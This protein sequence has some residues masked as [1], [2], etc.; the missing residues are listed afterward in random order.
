MSKK[1]P[2]L[3]HIIEIREMLARW[4]HIPAQT[5]ANTDKID[6]VDKKIEKISTTLNTLWSVILAIPLIGAIISGIGYAIKVTNSV[7]M[8]Q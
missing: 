4:E 6:N 5:K 1:E 2:I 3:D 8:R 7:E